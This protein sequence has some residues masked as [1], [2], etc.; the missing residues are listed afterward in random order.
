MKLFYKL[1]LPSDIINSDD[2]LSFWG[3]PYWHSIDFEM[4]FI[5]LN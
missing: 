3:I 1:E 5:I 2:R 4:I